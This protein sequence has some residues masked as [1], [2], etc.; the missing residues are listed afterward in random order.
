MSEK[1]IYQ[2]LKALEIEEDKQREEAISLIKALHTKGG[3]EFNDQKPKVSRSF[4]GIGKFSVGGRFIGWYRNDQKSGLP[5]QK[6]P[7]HQFLDKLYENFKQALVSTYP[8]S[9][10]G[11]ILAKK[12]AEARRENSLSNQIVMLYKEFALDGISKHERAKRIA[13]KLNCNVEYV[14]RVIRNT[15]N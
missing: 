2:H 10:T 11:T 14:R 13:Q 8:K 6:M 3:A 15:K 12:S 5:N 9:L 7:I 1:T 4:G